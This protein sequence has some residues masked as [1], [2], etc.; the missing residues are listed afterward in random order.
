[1]TFFVGSCNFCHY[2]KDDIDSLIQIVM[3]LCSDAAATLCQEPRATPSVAFNGKGKGALRPA[4][5]PPAKG[6]PPAKVAGP[7][8]GA[9]NFG[10]ETS[11][12]V[13]DW[14]LTN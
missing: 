8:G 6:L 13:L 1:M 9:F 4:M 14:K 3:Q 12:A 7:K 2:Q 5:A 11:V 10:R